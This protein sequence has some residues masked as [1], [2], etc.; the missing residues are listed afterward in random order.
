[1]NA[2]ARVTNLSIGVNFHRVT[3]ILLLLMAT[4]VLTAI[5]L[6]MLR[7]WLSRLWRTF[8][9]TKSEECGLHCQLGGDSM[10]ADL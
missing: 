7:S 9:I 1:M 3:A 8:V 2:C 4:V 10:D 6:L 5:L